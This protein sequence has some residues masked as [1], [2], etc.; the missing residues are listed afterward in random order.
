MFKSKEI[1]RFDVK[2][3][4]EQKAMITIDGK[5]TEEF[6]KGT[7]FF[8]YD[9]PTS[10]TINEKRTNTA[11]SL[12]GM[13]TSLTSAIVISEDE[14]KNG[15]ETNLDSL[16]MYSSIENLKK[17]RQTIVALNG[18]STSEELQDKSSNETA[19]KYD[20]ALGLAIGGKEAKEKI[21]IYYDEIILKNIK[22]NE[23]YLLYKDKKDLNGKLEGLL[24]GCYTFLSLDKKEQ[25][26]YYDIGNI[27]K[28][29][30]ML[31]ECY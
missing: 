31:D 5:L 6:Y 1:K 22:T 26:Q 9:N 12:V 13:S 27:A 15:Y 3:E 7:T 24:M 11:R 8:A 14:K 29:T 23:T 20:A 30:K 25:K 21:V 19:K 4:G 17:Y 10:S 18:Y 28:T 2:V 16:V